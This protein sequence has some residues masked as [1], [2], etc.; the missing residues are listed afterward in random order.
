MASPPP[1]KPVDGCH[2]R[3]ARRIDRHDVGRPNVE[4]LSVW[5][6]G[7]RGVKQLFSSQGNDIDNFLGRRVDDNNTASRNYGK[8]TR[9]GYFAVWRDGYAPL[10]EIKRR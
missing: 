2:D 7:Q 8:T 6:H 4:T 3:V 9:I 1:G 5:R 10:S